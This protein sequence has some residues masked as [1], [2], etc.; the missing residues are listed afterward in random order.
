MDRVIEYLLADIARIPEKCTAVRDAA[1]HIVSSS[2]FQSKVVLKTSVRL[3][4]LFVAN[5]AED[6]GCP[7]ENL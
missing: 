7:L 3:P 2:D 5:F 1:V 4:P 6:V